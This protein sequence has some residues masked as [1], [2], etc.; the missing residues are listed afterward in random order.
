MN[1]INIFFEWRNRALLQSYL[2]KVNQGQINPIIRL[3]E[4]FFNTC[5]MN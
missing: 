2:N 1:Y 3:C 4:I 5:L